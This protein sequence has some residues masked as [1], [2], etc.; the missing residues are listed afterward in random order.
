MTTSTD[1]D[2]G[3]SAGRMIGS[4]VRSVRA[5]RERTGDGMPFSQ[6][7]S[8]SG[9]SEAAARRIACEFVS[10]SHLEV[11][12]LFHVH[13]ISASDYNRELGGERK[14]GTWMVSFEYAGPPV[15]LDPNVV[16]TP[17]PDSP[18]TINVDDVS[19]EA[20]LFYLL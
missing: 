13:H 14:S 5:A 16:C 4:I 19:G 20:E 1:A 15:R 9:I 8:T 12:P 18:I 10:N 17:A 3:G 7:D 2:F 11:G 6:Q